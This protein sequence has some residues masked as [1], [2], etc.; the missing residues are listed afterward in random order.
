MQHLLTSLV[1][2]EI[3]KGGSGTASVGVLQDNLVLSTELVMSIGH[4]KE[5]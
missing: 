4:R 1:T 5:I 3:Y 2:Y